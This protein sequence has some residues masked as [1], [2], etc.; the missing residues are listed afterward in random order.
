[1][2][3]D[4]AVFRSPQESFADVFESIASSSSR[5]AHKDKEKRS[6]SLDSRWNEVTLKKAVCHLQAGN[7]TSVSSQD[8][9]RSKDV[10]AAENTLSY[11]KALRLHARVDFDCDDLE[12]TGVSGS[13]NSNP[14]DIKMKR[15]TTKALPSASVGPS[16]DLTKRRTRAQPA[17]N[18][19]NGN[20]LHDSSALPTK[21]SRDAR[22]RNSRAKKAAHTEG[23][24][25]HSSQKLATQPTSNSDR[26]TSGTNQ[27]GRKT[28]VTA[29]KKG[30]ELVP[31]ESADQPSIAKLHAPQQRR[32]VVSLRLT[33][34]EL[35]Q[36]RLRAEQSGINVSSYVRSCVMEAENL[37]SQVRHV[38]AEMRALGAAS[39]I[40]RHA[41][42]SIAH[43][44]ASEKVS[45]MQSLRKTTSI[46]V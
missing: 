1:M 13:F 31:I 37:R 34:E 10:T 24:A 3:R 35:E 8:P 21:L 2:N 40:Q 14:Q 42:P 7:P 15:S 18:R 12:L 4:S 22:R 16:S 41:L 26:Q 30:G 19:S 32:T 25:Q 36:L 23:P 44:A 11:E 38:M 43:Q 28:S 27:R 33:D 39:L 45:W 17:E 9:R 6:S 29:A 46:F 5:T 20:G